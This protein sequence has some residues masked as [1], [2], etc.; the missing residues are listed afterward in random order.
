MQQMIH[1]FGHDIAADKVLMVG[2]VELTHTKTV[3]VETGSGTVKMPGEG[4]T[5]IFRFKITLVGGTEFYAQHDDRDTVERGR[6]A[7]LDRLKGGNPVQVSVTQVKPAARPL[8]GYSMSGD[9]IV[10]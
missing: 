1:L 9:D 6:T 3:S 7:F 8:K 5:E 4:A 10:D 2:P